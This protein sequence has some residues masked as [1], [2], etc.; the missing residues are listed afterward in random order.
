[1]SRE[2]ASRLVDC[3]IAIVNKST[4]RGCDPRVA[5]LKLIA[6]TGTGSDNVDVATAKQCGVA[7][8]NTRGYGSTSVAQHV[9]ALVLG[10]TQQ[11]GGYAALV[12]GGAWQQRPMFTMF[13]YP[14]REL[15]GRTLGIVGSAT[16]T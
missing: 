3:E 9:F 14:L 8:A 13:D 10:L 11:I 15:S 7:V 6:L 4:S 5:R 2:V 12:R 16:N 1:M